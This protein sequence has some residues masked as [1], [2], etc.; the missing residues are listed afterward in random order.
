MERKSNIYLLTFYSI[1]I[2]LKFSC[3]SSIMS[4][5]TQSTEN[6]SASFTQIISTCSPDRPIVESGEVIHLKTFTN[7][8]NYQGL[9]YSWFATAGKIIGRGP[10]V[11]WD[12]ARVIPGT[13]KVTVQVT[14]SI[15]RADSCSIKV[16]IQLPITTKDPSRETGRSFLLKNKTEQKGYG[17]YS[18]LLFGSPPDTAS[19]ERYRKAIE[20]Y[21]NLIPD[22]VSLEKYIPIND[23]NITYLPIESSPGNNVS[24]DWILD[25]YDYARARSILRFLPGNHRHGPYIISCRK[26]LTGNTKLPDQYLYQNLSTV[27]AH[28]AL[29][30]VKEFL[31]QAAQE[32]FWERNNTEFFTLKLR[33]TIGI[34]AEG[35]PDVR[36]ALDK[37]IEWIH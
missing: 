17:L 7:A 9:K 4:K 19:R 36:N 21:L 34:L 2:C 29:L 8:E 37:W 13:Y 6:F 27:P 30:W 14:D 1:L 5:Q 20:T 31:N 22:I 16:I 32:R 33:T 23:L 15:G 12:F 35:L 28:L 24:I 25:N 10:E 3:T 18:Y 11:Q 26:P